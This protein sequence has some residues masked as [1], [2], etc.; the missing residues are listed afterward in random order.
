MRSR[1]P[2]SERTSQRIEELMGA[3]EAQ[4][5]D[6]LDRGYYERGS[7]AGEGYRSCYRKGRLKTAEGEVEY[8]ASRRS[9]ARRSRFARASV[10][11]SASGRRR[12]GAWRWRCTPGGS[13]RGTSRQPCATTRVVCSSR[14]RL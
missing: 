8:T 9:E 1:V 13:R 4:V 11:N 3:L 10:P 14:G 12:S 2:A 6:R 5:A 7:E